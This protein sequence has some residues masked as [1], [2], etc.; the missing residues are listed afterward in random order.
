MVI[1][2][3][4]KEMSVCVGGGGGSEYV[5]IYVNRSGMYSVTTS[6]EYTGGGIRGYS[7]RLQRG[8]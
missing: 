4:I 7:K 5:S 8:C 3:I 2:G 1:Q 6:L